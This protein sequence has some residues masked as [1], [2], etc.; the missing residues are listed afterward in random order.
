MKKID[1]KV[2]RNLK[3]HKGQYIAITLLITIGITI[4]LA[5]DLAVYNL[6]DTVDTYYEDYSL[7]D[8]Y[9]YG[10]NLEN[11]EEKISSLND[12]QESELRGVYEGK[13]VF[14]EDTAKLK[15]IS[16][17]EDINKVY[18]E[19]GDINIGKD[20]ILLF[21][22]FAD[23]REI[24]VGD[25]LTIR[26]SGVE[27]EVTVKGLV[28]NPEFIYLAESEKDMI[29]S[30]EDYGVAY[31]SDELMI[32][33]F[34]DNYYNEIIVKV[35]DQEEID[36]V[37]K[38][39]KDIVKE[40][41]IYPGIVLSK[42]E[43][44]SYRAAEEEINGEIAMSKS[45]PILFLIIA[46]IVMAVL[47]ARMVENERTEIGIMKALG[48]SNRR[49]INSYM[50]LTLIVGIIGAAFGMLIGG[51]ISYQFTKVYTAFFEIPI[52]VYNFDPKYLV[53]ALLIAVVL[54]SLSG[55]YGAKKILKL[56]PQESM[57]PKAPTIGKRL[58][59]EN[60]KFYN[61][62]KYTNKLVLRNISRNK[63]RFI[64]TIAGVAISFSMLLT[65]FAFY[66]LLD[67]MFTEQYT[68]V[69]VIDYDIS[70]NSFI[71]DEQL[72]QI[73][74]DIIGYSEGYLQIPIEINSDEDE[75]IL[76]TLGIEEDTQIYNLR[77][78]KG[79]EI[80][81]NDG[82][83]YVSEG[84]ALTNNI[85]KGDIINVNIVNK[86]KNMTE[87]K[88]IDIVDQKL[89]SNGYMTSNTLY[90]IFDMEEL[91]GGVSGDVYS[92]VYVQGKINEQ[93]LEKTGY[94]SSI[95]SV[96]KIISAYEEFTDLI[97]FSLGMLVIFGG[98][99]AFVI[100]YVVSIMNINERKAEFSSLR[101]LGLRNNEIYKII[102]RENIIASIIGI[103]LGIPLGVTMID[104]MSDSFS[105]DLYSLS[106]SFNATM[107]LYAGITTIIFVLIGQR[108][109]KNKIK[110]LD[111][112]EALKTRIS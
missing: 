64:L 15:F 17:T 49:I 75:A 31:L 21:K 76:M 38:E 103:I 95:F 6:R 40:E 34:G 32:E 87:V 108:V 96:E 65:P 90:R 9:V 78:T 53:L 16:V 82:E 74:E 94:I 2:L 24:N 18:V 97:Y 33:A 58:L 54:S 36:I 63:K 27:Y 107:Y 11:A 59:F 26:L 77:N 83:F 70:F 4:F 91:L 14:D 110:K 84:F 19:S 37:K 25:L 35:I 50:K 80:N 81:V 29:P 44:F 23:A 89:G 68:E 13:A 79:K 20:E 52:L 55:A 111:F 30:P 60:T 42:D 46:A 98:I 22:R 12:V 71:N 69:Q 57:R 92:G 56:L 43:Q 10:L 51:L 67:R 41:D 66:D 5:F 101:V 48:Y 102:F 7:S 99:I 62:L 106:V 105:N 61:K 47:V 85:E 72:K 28:Y 86:E 88:V 8:L 100:I 109:T 112:I 39:L 73:D 3:E 45:M 93:A 104:Y 1:A